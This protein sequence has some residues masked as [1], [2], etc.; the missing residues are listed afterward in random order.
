MTGPGQ[1]RTGLVPYSAS[2]RPPLRIEW[3]SQPDRPG[4]PVRLRDR[5]CFPAVF[6]I[7]LTVFVS[8]DTG[9][10]IFDTKLGV[11]IDP[12]GFLSRLW[13]LWNPLEWFGTLQDQYIGYAI[14]MAPFFL[15]GQLAHVPVWLTERLWLAVLV[16]VGFAGLV[17]L[18]RALRIGTDGTRLLAGGVFVLWPTFTI[19]IGSSSAAALPGLVV[20]WAILPLVGAVPTP[21]TKAP[22]ARKTLRPAGRAVALSGLAVA[23]M[24][25]VNAASTGCVLVLPALFILIE[26]RGRLRLSLLAKWAAAVLAG[27][28]WWLIPLL[29]Q[30]RY[31]FNF[32]PYIEQAGT[33]FRYMSA[34]AF[35]RGTGNW[36]AYLNLGTPWLSA[37]WAEVTSPAAILASATVAG[38][39]LYGLACRDMPARR[40]LLASVGLACAVTLTGYWGALGGPLSGPAD[41]LFDGALAP[42]RSLY[43][44]EPVVAVAL[45]LGC[46]HA[47]SRW[48]SG[49]LPV[50]AGRVPR[51]AA[52]APLAA[53]AVIGLAVPQL[54]GQVLQP[55]SFSQVPAY[56]SQVAAFLAANSPRQTA[57]VV[58]ADSHGLYLWGDPIDDP[59]EP[60]A[61]SPWAERALVPYGGAGS[62]VFLDTAEQ[63]IESDQAVPGLP[64]YLARAGIRYVVVRN[65]LNPATIGYVSPQI[66]NET[67]A[68]S[69]FERV[70]SFGPRIPSS[71]SY[72]Q[73]QPAAPGRVPSYPAVQVF[74]AADPAWRP[75]G[76]VAALPADRT[77]LVNGGPDSLLQLAGQGVVTSQPAVI[78][79]D[80]LPVRPDLWAVTDGQRRA[81]NEFGQTNQNV[82]FTYTA[83]ET[84]PPDDQ[85]GGAGGPPRQL[86]P[87][88]AA[89][90]QT[91]AVLSGAAQV[92]ASSYGDW[93][94][95]APQYDPVNAF[96]GDSATAWT[97]GSPYT[98]VG[99]WIQ[100]GFDRTLDL[101]AT[102]GI[103]LLADD[104][105]R[106]VAARV[107]VSTAA[108][109]VST[110]LA[111][112]GTVQ[113]LRVRPGATNWLR[114][115][116]TAA[117]NV[118]AGGPGAGF[119]GVLIPGVRVTRYL[120]PAED[121]AGT[122]ADSAVYS[123]RQQ[124]ASPAAASGPRAS[125]ALARTFQV[126]GEQQVGMTAAAVAVPGAALD[127]LIG[128]LA[129][130]GGSTF[131]ATASSTW[132]SLPRYG[133]DNLFSAAGDTPWI[134]SPADTSP[135]LHLTWKGIRTIST[136]IL[137]PASG[138]AFPAG[139]EV[140]SPRGARLA[141]VGPGGVVRLVP[142]L[143]TSQLYVIFPGAQSVAPSVSGQPGQFPVGLSKL[144]IPG[145]DGLRVAAP[146]D[147]ASFR[148]ACGRGP[149][150]SVDGK[151]Y[152]T[153]VSGTVADLIQF[154]PVEVRLC[155]PG[156]ELTLSDGRH[157]LL[158]APSS[159]FAI[160]DLNLRTRPAAAPASSA[161]TVSPASAAGSAGTA[162]S[163]SAAGPAATVSGGQR[164]AA[165]LTWQ[166]DSRSLRI[167]AG[168]ESYL[169]I[170]ENFNAGWSATLNGRPLS[171]VRLDGWQQAFIVPAG[172][173]GVIKLSY[174]PATVYHAGLIASGLA[175]AALAVLA[176][177]PCRRHRR[178]WH[179]RWDFRRSLGWDFRRHLRWDFWRHSAAGTGTATGPP[180][181]VSQAGSPPD[182]NGSRPPG[183]GRPAARTLAVFLPLAVVVWLAGGPAVAAVPVLACLGWWRPR[184]MPPV[185]FGA[186][187]LAGVVAASS[188]SPA[189]VGNG[190][191]SGLAQACALVALTAALMPQ[192][193][194]ATEDQADRSIPEQAG[195]AERAT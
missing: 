121:P 92:T 123:F 50:R 94:T 159:A 77:V 183:K 100:I 52:L 78:A 132:D 24:G 86:L 161:S 120:Q 110:S 104:P 80:P 175:L 102:I 118:V 97:E 170:H 168:T 10:M 9:R 53:L 21:A 60:L 157:R 95:Q 88:P 181:G 35:L 75:A 12:A 29:L 127:R 106:S 64:A 66:V 187:L 96:D 179:L 111:D 48:V 41:R 126:T 134:A 195:G 147:R 25:G 2:T 176:T 5:W 1:G 36:T 99:Q 128:S 103:Q 93:L 7:A 192:A 165:L 169:E 164:T 62:Q 125:Q 116:I 74:Q 8:T 79:G 152:P 15:L 124:A 171:P 155:A 27:T 130:A 105:S 188:G 32:L 68:L 173:G 112:T 39:G 16:T 49:E 114:V 56:W 33:T 182:G 143:R 135:L 177:G 6:L 37:G 108:G 113:A 136:L 47:V 59:P 90:H 65:D 17:R 193:A 150:V 81:D 61:D 156:G 42:L 139:V 119:A 69:G 149:A 46:A 76:P 89:G 109:S 137:T 19:V 20:P 141:S 194:R 38:A 160:T 83:T 98:A 142:P 22:L 34:A 129:P 30:G 117:S 57:L 145:L 189:A 87:V 43:K 122:R 167:G 51:S 55:G 91:V 70:T 184:W 133:P 67:L 11:D 163:A 178:R 63:A 40:W 158:A 140:A 54:S 18:A 174:G 58:P 162:S 190:A 13:Q 73:A 131:Q 85:F 45:A 185:A 186:M 172:Q 71:P 26:A 153:E 84:N 3:P 146:S 166:P 180:P 144:T 4:E 31:S 154:L 82:S 44:I 23:A 107:L 14:P 148:L 72:L 191:F 138:A 28:A 151:Q 115:T 101:P